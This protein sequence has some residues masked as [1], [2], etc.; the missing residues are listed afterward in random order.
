MVEK[1]KWS[2]M[3]PRARVG[4]VVLAVVELVL[5]ATALRDL[6]RRSREA[7][8]GP[9]VLWRLVCFVQPVGPVLYLLVGRRQGGKS[10]A[11]L[12]VTD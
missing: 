3:S 11:E 10:V 5:T 6:S 4:V 1:K 2:E 8:R 12:V 7:V 9:K